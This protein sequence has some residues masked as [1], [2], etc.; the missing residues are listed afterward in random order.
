MK[1]ILA[2]SGTIH[3][4][5]AGLLSTV[6]FFVY[7]K[8]KVEP[9]AFIMG[10]MTIALVYGFCFVISFALVKGGSSLFGFQSMNNQEILKYT[11]CFF[12]PVCC[13]FSIYI[14]FFGK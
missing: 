7:L 4:Y 14:H 8:K 2:L 9:V 3:G 6:L 11:G 13:I 5:F 10:L 12:L 1:I